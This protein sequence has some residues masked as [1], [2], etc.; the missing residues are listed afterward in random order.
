MLI[1][2]SLFKRGQNLNSL[3]FCGVE[4]R[5]IFFLGSVGSVWATRI[6]SVR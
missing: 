3:K 4:G 6:E 5:K 1:L 2:D